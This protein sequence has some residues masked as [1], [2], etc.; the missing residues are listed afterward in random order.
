TSE[1]VRV[2]GSAL[3]SLA[4]SAGR[5]VEGGVADVCVFDAGASWAVTP[6]QLAGQGK[7]TPF[8]FS[9]SGFELPARVRCTLVAGHIAFGE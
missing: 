5:L 8:E 7:H 9:R 6:D 4:A 2:L 3:G 1:P